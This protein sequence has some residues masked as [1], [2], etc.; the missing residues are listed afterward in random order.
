MT[1]VVSGAMQG[2][3]ICGKEPCNYHATKVAWKYSG[4][5]EFG[6][7]SVFPPAIVWGKEQLQE[8]DK[9]LVLLKH[10]VAY[11]NV[12]L[13]G[14]VGLVLDAVGEY[15]KSHATD[16]NGSL[17][18]A[19]QTWQL[20]T[21]LG[22][23]YGAGSWA[24]SPQQLSQY[25]ETVKVLQENGQDVSQVLRLG[26]ASGIHT[27]QEIFALALADI[28]NPKLT[29]IDSCSPPL[30]ESQHVAK[31]SIE[32][33][34]VGSV[35]S[36]P[37]N[38]IG[39]WPIVTA[40][41]LESFLPTKEQYMEQKLDNNASIQ[42]KI[43]HFSEVHKALV[44][45]GVFITAMGTSTPDRRFANEQ[46]MSDA[47]HSAGFLEKNTLIVPTTDPFDYQNGKHTEGNYFV[48]AQKEK[49]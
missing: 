6:P 48:V 25:V 12:S 8:I 21:K 19:W 2:L 44:P 27:Q 37:A 4:L 16:L 31:K 1:E 29:I 41:F 30:V 47:L 43:K 15:W 46:E 9:S 26:T 35:L 5:G 40:H 38:W 32:N 17:Y 36:L 28:K 20:Q 24:A 18:Q 23:K 34:T 14:K 7:T 11:E 33:T 39:K 10:D 22:L 49:I 13:L 42:L 3:N 45:E